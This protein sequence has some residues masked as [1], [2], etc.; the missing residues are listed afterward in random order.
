[1]T[2]YLD[3]SHRILTL[4]RQSLYKLFVF[5]LSLLIPDTVPSWTLRSDFPRVSNH[6]LPA[7]TLHPPTSL[8]R[9]IPRT[10]EGPISY[11]SKSPKGPKEPRR[12]GDLL[13]W[14]SSDYATV[15]V[16]L[17][18]PPLR[19]TYVGPKG[20]RR[21]AGVQGQR[22]RVPSRQPRRGDPAP[23]AGVAAG[24]DPVAEGQG[25]GPA[26]RFGS[27]TS[28]GTW[29]GERAAGAAAVLT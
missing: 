2:P 8:L 5:I 4:N 16:P 1:M 17:P 6:P 18:P 25:P 21:D 27:R 29:V 14:S 10:T 19:P 11:S 13:R 3:L 28:Q 9:S 12:A 26:H 23:A 7:V 22:S 20:G 15:L 24:S